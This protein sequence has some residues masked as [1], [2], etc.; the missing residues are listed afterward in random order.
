MQSTG[1]NEAS[2]MSTREKKGANYLRYLIVRDIVLRN[3]W[4]LWEEFIT[5][6]KKIKQILKGNY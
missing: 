1:E 2:R 5:G 6:M 3:H 4:N